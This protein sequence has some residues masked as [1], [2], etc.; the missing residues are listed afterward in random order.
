MIDG[1]QPAF[2]YAGLDS[3]TRSVVQQRT[4]ELKSLMYRTTQDIIEIGHKLIEVKA[5]IGHGNFGRWLEAEFS[6]S[7]PTAQRFMNVAEKFVKLTNLEIAPSALYEL[8]APSVPEA[9]RQEAIER[10]T[11]GEMISRMDAKAI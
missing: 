10:A 6:W 4:R 9:A 11:H 5:R 2:D 1:K 7:N 3:D 8:A